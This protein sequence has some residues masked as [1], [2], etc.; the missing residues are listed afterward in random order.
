MMVDRLIKM[1]EISRADLL[2][3]LNYNEE[4][5]DFTWKKTGRGRKAD[6]SAGW[7]GDQG[8]RIISIGG[9]SFRAHRLAWIY[10]HNRQ[11]KN[12]IDHIDGDRLNN[13]I[14]NLREA[15][16]QQNLQNAV[17]GKRSTSGFK[18][19]SWN[20]KNSN[21]RSQITFR[22]ENKYLGSFGTA[23]EAHAAYCA[24][25]DSMFGEFANYGT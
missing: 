14:S 11:P 20:N 9:R 17:V 4:T 18:G 6:C 13:K 15:T 16:P 19:A 1:L 23:E 25:A 12:L 22:G 7:I 5:G 24:A 2:P 21:W 8:Y 3:V 10:T